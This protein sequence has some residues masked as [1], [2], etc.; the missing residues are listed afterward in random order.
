MAK[1]IKYEVEGCLCKNKCPHTNN[2][3]GSIFCFHCQYNEHKR[4]VGQM[5]EEIHTQGKK[6]LCNHP[7]WMDDL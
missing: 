1:E 6:V 3:I 5:K 2:Y 7:K 4:T